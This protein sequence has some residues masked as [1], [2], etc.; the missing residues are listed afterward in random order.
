VARAEV[1][2]AEGRVA[3]VSSTEA[4]GRVAERVTVGAASPVRAAQLAAKAAV[5]V[6]V[7]AT[8]AA[9][10]VGMAARAVCLA[11]A[12]WMVAMVVGRASGMS[13][14]CRW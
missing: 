12:A 1:A 14:E 2:R 10:V 3:A 4:A 6:V 9:G 13:L 11:A 5:A 7:A 8:V